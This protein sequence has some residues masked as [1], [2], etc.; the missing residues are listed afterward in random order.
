MTPLLHYSPLLDYKTVIPLWPSEQILISFWT[1]NYQYITIH[2]ND[3][4]QMLN[5]N[6]ENKVVPPRDMMYNKLKEISTGAYDS[7]NADVD[8]ADL[9]AKDRHF[10]QLL[11]R[12]LLTKDGNSE[13]SQEMLNKEADDYL[14]QF[15]NTEH[16]RFIRIYI[17]YV[18]EESKWGFGMD[19]GSGYGILNGGLG[20]HFENNVP[21]VF[22]GDISYEKY[23]LYLRVY[24]GIGRTSQAFSYDGE[25][26]NNLDVN[27][28]VPELSLGYAMIDNHRFKL[29]PFAGLGF[30]KISPPEKE[31]EKDGNDVSL[32]RTTGYIFGLNVDY[33]LKHKAKGIFSS[34]ENSYW[35]IRFR[36]GYMIPNMDREDDR[37]DGGMTFFTVT[38]G[39]FSHPLKRRY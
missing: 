35:L 4:E 2:Y 10:L 7:L 25:W 34:H 28:E 15:P 6:Y 39:G 8:T 18:I 5:D 1:K 3:I 36:T 32:G 37:F 24:V 38:I 19:V 26:K 30:M 12:Y 22:G 23:L 11:L 17:R 29:A 20:D 14:A 9:N 16:S 21:V 31:K 27:I 33:K 13:F